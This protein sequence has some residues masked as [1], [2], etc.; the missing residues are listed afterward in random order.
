MERFLTEEEFLQITVEGDYETF[1]EVLSRVHTK[2]IERAILY[3]PTAVDSLAKNMAVT[4]KLFKEFIEAHE[5]YKEHK[6]LVLKIVQE[7][8]LRGHT[9][10]F[11][12]ILED[13]AKR[14]DEA[15]ARIEHIEGGLKNE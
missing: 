13:S 9:K 5:N 10:T 6:E 15:I 8:E 1:C 2:A 12:E 14:I 11:E 3:L 4:Q 7:E